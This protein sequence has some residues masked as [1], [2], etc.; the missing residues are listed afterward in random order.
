[1]RPR[2]GS[3]SPYWTEPH[4]EPEWIAVDEGEFWMGSDE[5]APGAY[6]DEHPAHRLWLPAFKISRVPVT[7]VQYALYAQATGCNPLRDWE[8][9]YMPKDKSH[10]PVVWVSWHD[11]CQYCRWLSEVTGQS[12]R[13]PSEA[14]WE[15]AARGAMDQRVYPWGETFDP[16]RCNSRELRLQDTTPVGMFPS[17]ASPY[18]CLDMAGNVW[19]WTRSLW[20]EDFDT[21]TFVYPYDRADGREDLQAPDEVRRVV[22]GGSILNSPPDVRCAVRYRFG[23]RVAGNSLGFRVVLSALP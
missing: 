6:S 13:L 21:P 23:A 17:G 4:G 10:H 8:D 5:N 18:G 7:N 20:G 14:E 16:L 1:M 12:I 15:K 3:H 9:G 22:R 2:F 11:A 19:E